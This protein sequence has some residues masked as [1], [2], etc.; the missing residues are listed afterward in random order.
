MHELSYPVAAWPP[1]ARLNFKNTDT[2]SGVLTG[3]KGQYLLFDSGVFNVR[4]H[5]GFEVT[6][7]IDATD[8]VPVANYASQID[9][10]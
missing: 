3:I 7:E 1:I 9:R 10:F 5:T 2:I 4:E 6:L 8:R